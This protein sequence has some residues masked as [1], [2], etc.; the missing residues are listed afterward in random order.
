[1]GFE[2]INIKIS[3]LKLFAD[4]A[5]VIDSPFFI[6]KAREIR[7]RY[8]IKESI[9]NT[10]YHWE[11]MKRVKHAKNLFDE[12]DDLRADMNLTVNYGTVC[13]KAVLGSEIQ[14]GDYESTYLINF[15]VIPEYF[16]ECVPKNELYGIVLTPQTRFEDVRRAFDEYSNIMKQMKNDED[17][18]DIFNDYD[19]V[20]ET[21]K[22]NIQVVR[23]WYWMRY[24]DV[25]LG[26]SAK[27]KP[28]SAVLKTW[29]DGCPKL[30]EHLENADE[31]SKCQHCSIDD[32]NLIEHLVPEYSRRL[33]KP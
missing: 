15:Q 29:Q 7:Y 27:P 23:R 9:T 26:K 16:L 10:D 8:G 32:Q 3:D 31:Y 24:G 17:A 28:Y 20:K 5:F 19:R 22:T 14:N 18:K 4:V 11:V 2:P 1:M 6:K 33:I 25:M 21:S 30:K 13:A 12:I